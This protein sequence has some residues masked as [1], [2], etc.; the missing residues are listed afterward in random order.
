MEKANHDKLFIRLFKIT[1][2]VL[3]IAFVAL[4]FSQ[5]TGY[6]EYELHKQVVFTEEQ[7]KQ[8]EADV[9]AGKNIDIEDYL[10]DYDKNYQNKISGTG[11]YLSEKISSGVRSGIRYIF[12]SL[13]NLIDDE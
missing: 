4:Y 8:F 10:K 1:F 9:A 7:I 3:A 13:N 5:I 11:L 6:Y 2:I 12:E